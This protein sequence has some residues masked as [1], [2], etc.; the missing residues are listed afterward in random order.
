MTV[1]QACLKIELIISGSPET[2]DFYLLSDLNHDDIT[3]SH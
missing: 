3:N 2:T 1:I